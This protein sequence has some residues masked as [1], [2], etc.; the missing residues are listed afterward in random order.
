MSSEASWLWGNTETQSHPAQCDRPF[1]LIHTVSPP[2]EVST[3]HHW[4]QTKEG[5][6][7]WDEWVKKQG[8]EISHLVSLFMP[9]I[10]YHMN[11]PNPF[12]SFTH[13]VS[14]VLQTC[15]SE[16]RDHTLTQLISRYYSNQTVCG[17]KVSSC[18]RPHILKHLLSVSVQEAFS[19]L[20]D[21][22]KL[23]EPCASRPTSAAA[24]QVGGKM[25]VTVNVKCL[26]LPSWLTL[27]QLLSNQKSREAF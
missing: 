9:S 10:N 5:D 6:S 2:E 15:G 1:L 8:R 7:R 11:L 16:N 3:A 13:L 27:P 18:T 20:C 25:C 17:Y 4:A 19:C 22:N 26:Y 24:F 14:H 23:N 12:H 21:A